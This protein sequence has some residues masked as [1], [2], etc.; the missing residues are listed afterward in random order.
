MQEYFYSNWSRTNFHKI[1]TVCLQV[2]KFIILCETYFFL[3]AIK[4]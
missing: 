3:F 4:K 2:V 1:I